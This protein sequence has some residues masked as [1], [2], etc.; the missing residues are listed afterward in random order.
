VEPRFYGKIIAKFRPKTDGKV[1]L[2]SSI[3]IT[4]LFI[5]TV[6]MVYFAPIGIDKLFFVVLFILF[7]YSKADYFWIAF[8][9]II[10]FYPAGLFTE[11]SSTDIRRLPIFSPIPKISFSVLDIF[12][13]I[14]LLKAFVKGKKDTFIDV[15]KLK[16]IVYIFPFIIIISFFYGVTLKPFL[17]TV[18]RGL[19]FYTLIYT[20][21]ALINN[22]K[23]LYKFMTMFFPFVFFEL[24]SQIF[25]IKMEINLGDLFN[26]GSQPEAFNSITGD[27]RVIPT[28]YVVVRVAF[29]FAFIMLDNLDRIISKSYSISIILI[30]ILSILLSATRSAIFM[31]IFIFILYFIFVARKKPN[32]FL[33][34]FITASIIVM[35]LDFS[36]MFDLNRIL[37][38]SYKRFV[39]AV[40]V[41]E[42]TLRPEDTFDH[43]IN[44]RLPQLVEHIKGSIFVGY[45]MSDKYLE[46]A[47]IHLGGLP[48]G[49]L[50]AGIIGYSFYVIFVFRIFKKC[51]FYIRKF[52]EDN[53]QVITIKVLLVGLFGYTIANFTIEPVFVL[54]ATT[55]PQDIILIFIITSMFIYFG[56]REQIMNRNKLK[57]KLVDVPE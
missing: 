1:V 47:D 26:P 9:I 40:S 50:Q 44:V 46:Y 10:S 37:G 34:L 48:V 23:D 28:G 19:F 12:L 27:I 38:A 49:L 15:F 14:S 36:N 2:Y 21:P 25:S 29:I 57:N 22:K 33:Q 56:M 6:Y 54:N 18:V 8:F 20:F 53:P 35:I 7:W 16:H 32:I 31:F 17:N 52:S 51:Y 42:G 41:E 4:I 39:G 30:S 5:I 24:A 13:I 11:S 45:G 43:R 55:S 3:A